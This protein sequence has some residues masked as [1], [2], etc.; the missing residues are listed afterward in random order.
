MSTPARIA[1]ISRLVL[2]TV[3]PGLLWVGCTM[4]EVKTGD[5]MAEQGRWDEAV[6]AYRVA[7]KKDP[8]DADIQK[9]LDQ[10]KARAAA[11]HYEAGRTYLKENRL[12]E[13]LYEFKT[14]LSLD[15]SREEH[16]AGFADVLRLKRAREELQNA[17]RLRSLGRLDEAMDAYERAVQMDPS[18]TQA[19][20]GITTVSSEQ[21]AIQS[22]GTPSQPITLR[23]QNARLREVFEILAR[24]GGINVLFDKDVRDDPVTIF[25]KETP[26]NEAMD[27]ILS[28][29]GLTAKRTNQDTVIVYPNTKPKRDQY[30]DMMIRTF[31][32]SNAKAKDMVN[33]VRTMLDTKKVYVNEPLNALVVRD[34]AAKLTLAERVILANDRRESEVLLDVEV[35]EVNRT[36]TLE[37]GLKYAKT[38]GF[39]VVPPG[40]TG[41]PTAGTFTFTFQQL[42]DLGPENYVVSLPTAV[43]VDFFKQASD[44]KTIASPKIRVINGKQAVINVGDK[45]PILLSTT[46]VLPG[47]AA[48]GAVPTTS[49]VTSIEFKDTGLK[50]TVEPIVHLSDEITLKLKIEVT[51]LGDRVILQSSPEISQ[52]RFGT[53]VAETT[54]NMKHDETVLLAGLIQDDERKTIQG[55]PWIDDIPLLGPLLRSTKKETVETEIVL[56]ITPRVLRNVEPPAL[57]AQAFWSGTET[58]FAA[59]PLNGSPRRVSLAPTSPGAGP[60]LGPAPSTM[61]PPTGQESAGQPGQAPAGPPAVPPA[62]A[63]AGQPAPQG[64]PGAGPPVTGGSPAPPVP[65]GGEA[66]RPATDTVAS[67]G[68]PTLGIRPAELSAL[69]GQEFR[70]DLTADQ[71]GAMKESLVSIGFDPQALEFHRADAG[72]ASVSVTPG[73]GRVMVSLV[74]RGQPTGNQVVASLVFQARTRGEFP[75]TIQ[76][77]V[78]TGEG[79]KAV[80]ITT[81]RTLVRVR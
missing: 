51:R 79:N 44:S 67:L 48:T 17:E 46:N 47:Q 7:S 42:S 38:A 56:T 15:P 70:V 80:T 16:H 66:Q 33:L 10:A 35:F 49:T 64:S 27:L 23:F 72:A 6:A 41:P 2:T 36:K 81:A 20:E 11:Q 62:P 57:G 25:I 21:Q 78:V 63:A 34:T 28:L 13:S 9:R 74:P 45:Q 53:R 71:V 30:E 3:V 40:F 52:F 55:I 43:I 58:D 24:T 1:L 8:F 12:A 75:V 14:A 31:Y 29:N 68:P 73:P 65:P 50:L 76:Q 39:G 60:S 5:E 54:L 69:I 22:F 59:G 37:F 19:L 18:L 32:L 61:L 4:K 26:F 77:A